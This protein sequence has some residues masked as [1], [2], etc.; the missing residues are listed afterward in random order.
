MKKWRKNRVLHVMQE[1][2]VHVIQVRVVT[3]YIL[4]L[5]ITECYLTS[6]L[7]DSPVSVIETYNLD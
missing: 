6:A 1:G 4:S 7:P 2:R 5:L 3:D